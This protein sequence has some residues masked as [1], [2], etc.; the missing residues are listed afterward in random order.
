MNE[1]TKTYV[2]ESFSS[3][4]ASCG[5]ATERLC[6]DLI[7]VSDL[8]LEDAMHMHSK[9]SDLLLRQNIIN[10]KGNDS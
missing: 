4:I 5:M 3:A 10:F 2:D 9:V 8:K 7:R 6:Y 1:V